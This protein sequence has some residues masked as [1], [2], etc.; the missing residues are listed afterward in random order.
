MSLRR[1]ITLHEDSIFQ[2][3]IF[4]NGKTGK[5]YFG[6]I[7]KIKLSSH[8]KNK[9]V[10]MIKQQ[11]KVDNLLANMRFFN[12]D[13]IIF[14]NVPLDYDL[15]LETF[16]TDN[17]RTINP[18]KIHLLMLI[19][20][21]IKKLHKIKV[22]H[23]DI[24]PENIFVNTNK[25]QIIFINHKIKDTLLEAIDINILN[26]IRFLNY[27]APEQ[28]N[29]E[30][31][32]GNKQ[33]IDIY[34]LGVLMYEYLTGTLPF[35]Y[36]RII[37]VISGILT[38]Q[39]I[40]PIEINPIIPKAL[41]DIIMKCLSKD[42]EKRP[43]LDSII[44]V[45]KNISGELNTLLILKNNFKDIYKMILMGDY[46]EVRK[47][48]E[49]IISKEK[50][51]ESCFAKYLMGF[52]FSLQKKN[53]HAQRAFMEAIDI[54]YFGVTTAMKEFLIENRDTLMNLGL[55][56]YR[57]QYFK[58]S[59]KIFKLILDEYPSYLPALRYLALSQAK[60]GKYEDAIINLEKIISLDPKYGK[61]YVDLAKIYIQKG[62]IDEAIK[63]LENALSVDDKLFAAWSYLGEL[64]M[65]KENYQKA[66]IC[67][68]NALLEQQNSSLTYRLLG[69]AYYK[70]GNLEKA[71]YMLEKALNLNEK[72]T[73][74]MEYLGDIY[75]YKRDYKQA[76]KFYKKIIDTGVMSYRVF[77]K[78]GVIEYNL[79]NYEKALEYF[80]NARKIRSNYKILISIARTYYAMKKYSDALIYLE[81]A[82]K[83][84]PNSYLV[85]RY[86]AMVLPKLNRVSESIKLIN[87]ILK[88]YPDDYEILLIKGIIERRY[89]QKYKESIKT[90][91]SV[92]K[93]NPNNLKAKFE[94]ALSYYFSKEYKNA[95]NV[96]NDILT[97]QDNPNAYRL[98]GLIYYK[99]CKFDKALEYFKK[100]LEL[101]QKK[102][103]SNKAYITKYSIAI[104]LF[105]MKRYKDALNIV[106][107]ML[108]EKKTFKTLIL[109]VN[110]LIK[111]KKYNDALSMIEQAY[112]LK[113]KSVI[114]TYLKGKILY[115]LGKYND[116]IA[117][118]L[119]A[120][121][122]KI[123]VAKDEIF[124]LLA[125]I[126]Q[127]LNDY[128]NAILYLKKYLEKKPRENT[129]KYRIAKLLLNLDHYEDAL[130]YLQEIES[131][132]EKNPDY[133]LHL[134]KTYIALRKYNDAKDALTRALT[135][136]KDFDEAKRELN[137]LEAL[138]KNKSGSKKV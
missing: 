119:P 66:I 125:N 2:I 57:K 61:A 18:D 5:E 95:I 74:A 123:D 132:F 23:C 65:K 25:K 112:E 15:M 6:E 44:S 38:K 49:S 3:S 35:S 78:I 81:M 58:D 30:L 54:S 98:F 26:D 51:I 111:L 29:R 16:K 96:L 77:R 137:N 94:L 113:P 24:R 83:D 91:S 76:L 12:D 1:S 39:P 32:R 85:K 75:F 21:G 22:Y 84:N 104:T 71:V 124:M 92:L 67:L 136:K 131:T 107:S 41:N 73:I 31:F 62:D 108:N 14:E 115:K 10:E 120:T 127:N 52:M 99:Q 33:L 97:T 28:I 20:N 64:Y 133:W 118:L 126:Y 45:I 72:D 11:P 69:E 121:A 128:E 130:S 34:Q 101:Y 55:S 63:C 103:M 68:Q 90:L 86:K 40:Q 36:K 102:G 43:S 19:I 89:L 56:F 105:K 138:M 53:T 122:A 109:G 79:K 70:S 114:A 46:P 87:S 47:K 110:I 106:N 13:I 4:L 129:I 135:L 37:D 8:L 9:L 93:N 80:N 116:A 59:E 100:G 50:G 17:N 117:C 7:I 134:G 60:Q 48:L 42:P 88:K 27:L 82:E